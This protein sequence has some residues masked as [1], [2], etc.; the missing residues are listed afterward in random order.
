MWRQVLE[1]GDVV[2][3]L[4]IAGR[5]LITLSSRGKYLRAWSMKDG[6]L[7]WEVTTYTAAAPSAAAASEAERDRGVDV[8]PLGED[9]DADGAEDVLVLARGEVQ[10]RSVADGIVTWSTE[11]AAAFEK[12]TVRLHRVALAKDR[13]RIVAVGVTEEDGY[14]AAVELAVK[15][16]SVTRKAVGSSVGGLTNL[17]TAT[18]LK[19]DPGGG[20]EIWVMVPLQDGA[21]VAVVDVARLLAGK[22]AVTTVPLPALASA[23]DGDAGVEMRAVRGTDAASDLAAIA[24]GAAVV[25]GA[26]GCALVTLDAAAKAPA[27][28]GSWPLSP[29]GHHC[30]AAVSAAFVE[31]E[32]TKEH[33]R[34]AVVT[35]EEGTAGGV[36]AAVYALSTAHAGDGPVR[37]GAFAHAGVASTA[38]A[39]WAHAFP[40]R[41]QGREETIAYGVLVVTSDARLALLPLDEKKQGKEAWAREESLA[42]AAE[43]VF[44]RLPPPKS[45]AIA[46]ADDSR[47]R[48]SFRERYETQ[49]LAL[50]ARFKTATPDEIAELTALRRGR[51]VKLLPTRDANGFRRQIVAL[52][53][54]GAL[55][56]LHNGDGRIMWRRFLGGG[57]DPEG[58]PAGDYN[59][60]AVFAPWRLSQADRRPTRGDDHDHGEHALV[61]ATATRGGGGAKTRATVV[62]LYSGAVVSDVVLPY[63]AA[64]VL[65]VAITGDNLKDHAHDHEPS[66][67]LLVDEAGSRAHVFPNTKEAKMAAYA[68]RS[69]VSFFT[70]DQARAE[71]R[72]Y[73]LIPV[74]P[75]EHDVDDFAAS[76]ATAQTW[77]SKFSPELGDIVGFAAKPAGE[78]VHSWVRVLGDRSTLF[79]YLSPNVVFVATAPKGADS[80]DT[81]VSVHLLDA[82]TGRV[83]YRVRHTEARGPVHAVVC[84]NWVVYHYFNTRAGRY[85][86][87][88]L[89][90]FDDAEHRK[91]TA[92]GDLVY[93]S[94]VG[95]NE[96]ETV[97]SLAPPPLRIMGQSYFVRPAATMMTATYSQKGV[98]AHQI[99]MGTA[100][101][102][103]VA[104]DKRFL[105]PRRPTKPSAEDREEGLIPYAEVLPI[106]PASWVTT[107]HQVS[108]LRGIKTA[109][110]SLESTVL[111]VAHGLDL[112]YTRL[113]PSRSYDMLDEEFSYLLLIVTLAALAV[114]AFATQGLAYVKD[115]DRRWR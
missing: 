66:A 48:P 34:V 106:F 96:T 26:R 28:L 25:R 105:D 103:V 92:V 7:L 16:G 115:I 18:A 91:G 60:S 93:A 8:L 59:Y 83:L 100:T 52:A 19:T 39:A 70:V 111:C 67:V 53:P 68:Q 22:R 80:R 65:P 90:M 88:V 54:N 15:D 71:V 95:T 47:V 56:S 4:F 51:G 112:F 62:D 38:T 49:V 89:E 94:V 41:K 33:A 1:V 64:H 81:A 43:L 98:T 78:V 87:S 2:D 99:L 31:S 6:N 24:S 63:A 108:R 61:L 75:H 10:L 104:L 32:A 86:M 69:R 20:E 13:T 23:E 77:T 58:N 17:P 21:K 29:G 36:S 44:A 57:L 46:A 97:S 27:I 73:A 50:K 9:V 45:A 76:Y 84:E 109:P 30:S 55:V 5:Q 85:A 114:G 72:G 82:A 113:H 101:D 12:E 40:I 107:R 3:R 74:T 11:A 35:T 102:Q 37:V 14:P 42:L 79:K 110:A